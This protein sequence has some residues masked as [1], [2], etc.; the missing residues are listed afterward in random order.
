MRI[1]RFL[2]LFFIILAVALIAAAQIQVRVKFA[3]IPNLT[4]RLDCVSDLPINCSRQNL[5]ELWTR[6]FLK[7][8][9]DRR[10]LK[11]WARLRDLYSKDIELSKNTNAN[12]SALNSFDKIRIAGFQGNDAEDYLARLDLLTAPRDHASFARIINYFE[13]KFKIWRQSEAEKTGREFA[14]QTDVLLRSP[15]ISEP[16]KGFYNFYAPVLPADYEISFNL[17]Y[18]PA[19]IKEQTSGQQLENYSLWNSK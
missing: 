11:E 10:M 13:P 12:P 3:E 1:N 14:K 19:A 2:V 8:D 15:K 9:E 5:G 4:Y 6:E 7:T 18:I 17:F 16:V